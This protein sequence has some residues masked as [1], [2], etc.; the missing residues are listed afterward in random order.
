[1]GCLH[2]L[3]GS[4]WPWPVG[5]GHGGCVGVLHTRTDSDWEIASRT[6][7]ITIDSSTGPVSPICAS[8]R[9]GLA[10]VVRAAGRDGDR[11]GVFAII[12]GFLQGIDLLLNHFTLIVLEQVLPVVPQ[13]NGCRCRHV[14]A[15]LLQVA[16][17][18]LG[19]AVDHRR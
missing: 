5:N 1:M 6:H 8:V 7:C 16:V 11:S 13:V 19:T 10:S 17:G 3:Q 2:S 4:F 14:Q 15:V 9:V 12:D 18:A